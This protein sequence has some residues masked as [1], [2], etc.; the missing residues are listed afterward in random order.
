[1]TP[2]KARLLRS[3]S[4]CHQEIEDLLANDHRELIGDFSKVWGVGVLPPEQKG[5]PSAEPCAGVRPRPSWWHL[6]GDKGTWGCD[7]PA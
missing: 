1:M 7:F 2:Q 4:F 3:R 6:L 5:G